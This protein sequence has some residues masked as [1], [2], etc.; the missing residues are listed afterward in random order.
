M[1][2]SE[3]FLQ[4]WQDITGWLALFYSLLTLG[5]L[6][7]VLHVKRETMSAIAWS[8]TVL[9]LPLIG[10]FLFFVFGAQ[11]ITRPLTRKQQKKSAYRKISGLVDVKPSV[12]VPAR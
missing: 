4:R 1:S 8:L 11:S 7:W 9:L 6:C 3:F 12:D 5:T 10:A 2:L